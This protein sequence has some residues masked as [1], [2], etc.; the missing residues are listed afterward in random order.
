MRIPYRLWA[1]LLPIQLIL[2]MGVMGLLAGVAIGFLVV[3]L[4]GEIHAAQSALPGHPSTERLAQKTI[5]PLFTPEVQFWAPWIIKWSQQYGIDPDMLATVIQ[6]ESCG[7]YLVSSPAGAQGLFQVMPFHFAEGESML[8]PETNARRGIGYLLG[9]LRRADGHIGL[10]LAGYNGGW[11]VIP[12]GWGKWAQQ[13]RNYY[14]WGSQIYMDA[15]VGK[16]ESAALQNW[17]LA[18][19]INLCMKAA[20]AIAPLQATPQAGQ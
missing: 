2:I 9:S 5:A 10:A 11:G 16:K 13:T 7:H 3:L 4:R 18:G 1:R 14:I 17:L 20:Q 8:D 19:G 12:L 6:I 15:L